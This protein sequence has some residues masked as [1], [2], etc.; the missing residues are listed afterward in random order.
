MDNIEAKR[1]VELGLEHR[2]A[3]R[4]EAEKDAFLDAYEQQQ[5]QCC[6]TNF[7]TAKMKREAEEATRR[8]IAEAAERQKARAAELAKE[9]AR[10]NAAMAAW[11]YYGA[12]CIALLL[13][14]ALT[15]MPLWA[16]ITL[17][18]GLAVFPAAYIFR[19]YYPLEGG[20]ENG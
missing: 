7:A 13:L 20:S 2:R 6:N 15:R 4:E 11:R 8:K 9:M 5:I 17:A 16:A 19:L 12:A 1:L 14:T 18:L 3:E 10:E